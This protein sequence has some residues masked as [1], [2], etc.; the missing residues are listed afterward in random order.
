MFLA[1]FKFPEL[2]FGFFSECLILNQSFLQIF[3]G[4]SVF[5][6]LVGTSPP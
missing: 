3:V 5:F 1:S 4:T 2:L 6:A